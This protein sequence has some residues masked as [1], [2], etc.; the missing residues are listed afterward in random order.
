M[1]KILGKEVTEFFHTRTKK[2]SELPKFAQEE[3]DSILKW[4]KY[5]TN[6]DDKEPTGHIEIFKE[7]TSSIDEILEEEFNVIHKKGSIVYTEDKGNNIFAVC[8]LGAADFDEANDIVE[9][10]NKY[11]D[12]PD[13]KMWFVGNPTEEYVWI[14]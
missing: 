1:P 2:Y 14:E 12:H 7:N 5:R 6:D 3:V 4:K 10:L 8:L 11:N 9:Q 13:G